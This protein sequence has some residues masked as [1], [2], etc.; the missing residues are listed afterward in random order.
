[1]EHPFCLALLYR[2]ASGR[3]SRIS[4]P[5]NTRMRIPLVL[6]ILCSRDALALTAWPKLPAEFCNARADAP[7]PLVTGYKHADLWHSYAPSARSTVPAGRLLNVSGR[8]PGKG[9]STNF[10]YQPMGS[11]DCYDLSVGGLVADGCGSVSGSERRVLPLRTSRG[12]TGE[13]FYP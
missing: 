1:M 12:C 11:E 13:P 4:L 6:L 2:C 9:Y 7:L 8:G 5:L 10:R 3:A